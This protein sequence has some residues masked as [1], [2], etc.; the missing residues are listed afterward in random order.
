MQAMLA[1][2]RKR[3]KSV[4]P[5]WARRRYRELEKAIWTFR[6]SLGQEVRTCQVG[7]T[8]IRIG[9]SSEMERFR[10]NTY[11]VKEPETIEWLTRNVRRGDVFFDI[12]AN[13][14]LY[15]LYAARLNPECTVYAF[16]PESQNYA[17]LCA[18]IVLN[19]LQ[20]VI[21]CNAPLAERERLDYFYVRSWQAGSALHSFGQSLTTGR[22]VLRQAAISVSLDCLTGAH[23]IPQPN[24]IKLDVDGIEDQILA[25]ATNVLKSPALRSILM[26]INIG[27]NSE[28]D[29]A[30]IAGLQAAGFRVAGKSDWIN[31]QDGM[32]SQNFIFTR[33]RG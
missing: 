11:A 31:E 10:A 1:Q 21:P 23:H 13:V 20:N 17:R 28:K 8:R 3:L 9:V 29:A 27:S 6:W 16:E 26:E 24:L 12:G 18:N 7:G 25:G 19:R 2:A 14:G 32:T 22:P 33:G 4:T 5:K 15:A 30:I